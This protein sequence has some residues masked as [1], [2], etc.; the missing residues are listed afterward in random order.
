MTLSENIF[1]RK[2]YKGGLLKKNTIR[3]KFV[4]AGWI[5]FALPPHICLL[6]KNKNIFIFIC[7]FQEG[8]IIVNKGRNA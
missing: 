6:T 5:N 2:R 1:I 4:C 8:D 7:I 3:I